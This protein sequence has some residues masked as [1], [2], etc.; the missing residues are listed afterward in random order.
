M[1]LSN[2]PKGEKKSLPYR[3]RASVNLH[4][5]HQ[6]EE[7]FDVCDFNHD[8]D[9]G[10]GWVILNITEVADHWDFHPQLSF[11]NRVYTEWYDKGKT[12]LCVQII[13]C[14]RHLVGETNKWIMT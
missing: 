7:K 6:N 8:I 9:I 5:R 10:V 11:N 12:S 13:G 4:I 1:Q 3:S 2:Q 14:L